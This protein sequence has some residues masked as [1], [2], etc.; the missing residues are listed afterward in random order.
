[1]SF[2]AD[3]KDDSTVRHWLQI[4]S[5]QHC[6]KERSKSENQH[7]FR[8][9]S[10]QVKGQQCMTRRGKTDKVMNEVRELRIKNKNAKVM[11]AWIAISYV[12]LN[13]SPS[14]PSLT[15]HFCYAHEDPGSRQSVETTGYH[16]VTNFYFLPCL[17][18]CVDTPFTLYSTLE[19]FIHIFTC[20]FMCLSLV[21][22]QYDALFDNVNINSKVQ[23][24]D[25]LTVNISLYFRVLC[26]AFGIPS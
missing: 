25:Q 7:F 18:P 16:P 6:G 21:Q 10:Q 17:H 13:C 24:S 8:F 3:Q 23:M 2:A 19:L 15:F 26:V 5:S 20:S 11:K 9:C 14:N 1:M 22:L 12:K 4:P